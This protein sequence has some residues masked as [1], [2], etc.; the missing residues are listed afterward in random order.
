MFT[1]LR[2]LSIL[3]GKLDYDK[4]LQKMKVLKSLT[5]NFENYNLFDD[6]YTQSQSLRKLIFTSEYF[7]ENDK[8]LCIFEKIIQ[9]VKLSVMKRIQP[10]TLTFCDVDIKTSVLLMKLLEEESDDVNKIF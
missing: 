6:I 1:N 2:S 3:I 10:L 9:T 5:F 7:Y 4:S 8:L